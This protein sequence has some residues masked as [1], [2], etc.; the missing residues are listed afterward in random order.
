MARL[1]VKVDGDDVTAE[2]M[3]S[4]ATL[5]LKLL[6]DIE[7]SRPG[8]KKKIRWRVDIMSGYSYGLIAIRAEPPAD[9]PDVL[10][11]AEA[12]FAQFRK[13]ANPVQE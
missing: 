8:P 2:K 12:I 11:E 7:K 10:G 4:A 6:R 9:G 13:T 3:L 1:E 5:T